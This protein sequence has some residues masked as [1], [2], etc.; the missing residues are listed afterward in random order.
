MA[1]EVTTVQ[2]TSSLQMQ[3]FLKLLLTQMTIQ[4]PL[5]PQNPQDF[6]VQIAQFTNLQQTQQISQNT[7][8]MLTTDLSTQSITLLGRKVGVIVGNSTTPVSGTVTGIRFDRG[9]SLMSIAP[10]SPGTAPLVDIP[11]SQIA[12]IQ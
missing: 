7:S 3:D 4:D 1:N 5:S 6:M 11:L 12:N 10:T 2:S 8:Q 9:Q